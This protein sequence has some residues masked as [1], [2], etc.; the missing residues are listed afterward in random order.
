MTLRR[1][2]PRNRLLDLAFSVGS[3]VAPI[4]FGS[5]ARKKARGRLLVG[6]A[7]VDLVSKANI[8]ANEI[9]SSM[10]QQAIEALRAIS[11]LT[12][13]LSD[14]AGTLPKGER[15]AAI[16]QI[17]EALDLPVFAFTE[18]WVKVIEVMIASNKA[19]IASARKRNK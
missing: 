9:Q 17:Q 5:E 7:V 2:Q 4:F 8:V 19:A 6:P 18:A 10:G 1:Q 15:T 14:L 16:N 11:K 3:T 13:E 12:D